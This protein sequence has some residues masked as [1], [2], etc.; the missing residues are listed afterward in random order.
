M[1][2]T[3]EDASI[4]SLS[5][6]PNAGEGGRRPDEGAHVCPSVTLT[7]PDPASGSRP[8]SPGFGRGDG[9]R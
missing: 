3:D 7:R 4:A 5:L 1:D 2:V 8:T 9:W 6:L